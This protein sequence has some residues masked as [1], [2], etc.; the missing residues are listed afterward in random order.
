MIDEEVE[1]ICW[2][3]VVTAS[4]SAVALVSGLFW[5]IRNFSASE[6]PWRDWTRFQRL[7]FCSCIFGIP[8][9]LASVA[10]VLLSMNFAPER[11]TKTA[12]TESF[13]SDQGAVKLLVSVAELIGQSL[14]PVTVFCYFLVLMERLSAYQF[15]LPRR[16]FQVIYTTIFILGVFLFLAME[17]PNILINVLPMSTTLVQVAVICGTLLIVAAT[18]TEWT[19]SIALCRV[20]L[21]K[22]S[23]PAPAHESWSLARRSVQPNHPAF[24]YAQ[25]LSHTKS[26][27]YPPNALSASPSNSVSF[28]IQGNGTPTFQLNSANSSEQLQS[29]SHISSSGSSFR[30]IIGDPDKRRTVLLFCGFALTDL[31]GYAI[32]CLVFIPGSE[33]MALPLSIIGRSSI[34]LHIMLTL[35]FL[36]S[37]KQILGRGDVQS[38]IAG[39]RR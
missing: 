30:T 9:Y 14:L 35:I 1:F 20:F 16:N 3:A 34:G 23:S 15:I 27:Q 36:D 13:I 2:I 8:V 17:A 25:H 10:E 28:T 7:S 38:S 22:V 29:R 21:F 24:E 33:R 18:I 19:L 26:S 37:F 31:V 32:Y 5:C 4:G 12:G 6:H 11:L 39:T